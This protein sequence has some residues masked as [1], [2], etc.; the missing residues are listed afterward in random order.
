MPKLNVAAVAVVV[1]LSMS[2]Q[3]MSMILKR[4]ADGPPPGIAAGPPPGIP[5]G[6]PPG[7]PAGPPSGLPPFLVSGDCPV[8]KTAETFDKEKVTWPFNSSSKLSC[9]EIEVLC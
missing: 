9:N 2:T 6:P 5:G 8:T 3:S 4:Q 1:V 7:I